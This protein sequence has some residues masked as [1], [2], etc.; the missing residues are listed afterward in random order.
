MNIASLCFT[1]KTLS[2]KAKHPYGPDP[3]VPL[4]AVLS[5][6]APALAV[7]ASCIVLL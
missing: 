4:V 5:K 7:P 6:L 3:V 2:H 1:T